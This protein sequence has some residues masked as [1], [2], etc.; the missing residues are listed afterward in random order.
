MKISPVAE[1]L[2]E[3]DRQ[4]RQTSADI[5]TAIAAKQW[6]LSNSRETRPYNSFSRPLFPPRAR[7]TEAW[8]SRPK[9]PNNTFFAA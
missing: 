5:S 9:S 2:I 1:K 8:I 6:M 7:Q 4:S 3:I